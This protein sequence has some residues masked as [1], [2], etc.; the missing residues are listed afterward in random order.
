MAM[1]QLYAW[2]VLAIQLTSSQ[3]THDVSQQENDVSSCVDTKQVLSEL[4]TA[5]SRVEMRLSQLQSDIAE[6]KADSQQ[7]TAPPVAGIR[8]Y[9]WNLKLNRH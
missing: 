1:L 2:A 6:L 4:V 8:S 3:P 7:T 5:V 9:R